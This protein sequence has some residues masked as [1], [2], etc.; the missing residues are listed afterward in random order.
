M[1]A[2]A[3][4]AVAHTNMRSL[5]VFSHLRWDFVRQRPQHV[6]TRLAQQWRILFV[7]EPVFD[8]RDPWAELH[9]PATNITVMRPHTPLTAPGFHDDQIPLLRKLLAR[10]VAR[11]RLG[12]YGA[13]LYTP[14]ALPLL[15]KLSPRALVYDCTD[16]L[17]GW[18]H[19]P[20]QL[21]QRE[22]ALL[23]MA[24]VVFT[25]SPTLH[26]ARVGRNPEVHLV[27]SGV[28]R[29]HFARAIDARIAAPQVRSCARPRLV[30]CGVIDERIDLALLRGIAASRPEWELC[31]VG[32]VARID[33]A[34]L[35]Q[36]PNLHYFGAQRYDDLPAFL[37]GCD[38]A[39]LPFTRE[40][41]TRFVCPTKTLEYMAAEKP[42]VATPITD[43]RRLYAD[44]V[45][46]ADT[47]EAFV[48]ACERLLLE[49]GGA[50]AAAMGAIAARR[51]WDD[52]ASEM[53]V[54]VE[55]AALRGPT[56]TAARMYRAASGQRTQP[57][58]AGITRP[59]TSECVVVG[60][61]ATGLSAAYHYGPGALL[62]DRGARVGG[63]C[64]SVEDTGFT[65]DRGGHALVSND[66]F[67]RDLCRLLLGDNVHWQD[68]E[69]GVVRDGEIVP[70]RP[71][72]RTR[73]GYP[74]RGGF[75]ALCAGFLP[76]LRADVELNAAVA[77]ISPLRR[78]VTLRDGR[79]IGYRTLISTMPLPRLIEAL[80]DD[81]PAPLRRCAA[82][83]RHR[84]MRCVNLGVG[85]PHLTDRHWLTFPG[86]A[87]IER[88]FMQGNASPLCNPPGGFGLTCE[89][90][91]SPARP[92]PATGRALID[93]CLGLCIAIGL[94]KPSDPIL[95]ANEID[96]PYA[97]PVDDALRASVVSEARD[98]L[99]RFGIVLAGR[100]GEW[101][102]E[103]AAH[104]F[105]AGRDAAS[106]ARDGAPAA[107]RTA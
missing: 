39:L 35:P 95:T 82:A 87:W 4:R 86:D 102:A 34:T 27:R 43:V 53:R 21:V 58:S 42:I 107:A 93:R 65:F 3:R 76:L 70:C 37:A 48:A 67:V 98:W 83:L 57:A 38:I 44:V 80:G 81:V 32:P 36:A 8:A 62:L 101:Q 73:F 23:A 55:R 12:S 59:F 20:R 1:Q 51:S 106:T 71:E 75:E 69:T 33:P 105:V 19:A 78:S 6:L 47:A 79:R 31:I 64:R 103:R 52:A 94:V 92:L 89:I 90:P 18:R 29:A 16:E 41:A 96:L 10:A 50:R 9:A 104:P 85:R 72:S 66:P 63:G 97:G 61:G 49:S 5:I 17:R 26:D 14:M 68:A 77:R 88:I 100:D 46:F 7:E 30:Y 24:N 74:L 15:Q 56:E 11:E 45:E 60:A 99:A 25:A 84:S 2:A 13:W 54:H 91:Y 40:A 28:D 22:N